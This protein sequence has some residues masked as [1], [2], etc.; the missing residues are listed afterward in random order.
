MLYIEELRLRNYRNYEEQRLT[1]NQ[2]VNIFVGENGQGKTNLLES[3]YYLATGGNFRGNKDL[4]LIR[5]DAPYFRLEARLKKETSSRYFDLEIYADRERNKQL[6]INGVKYK[7]MAEL[8][9]YLQV[10]LFSPE[11]LKIIKGGRRSADA[12][13]MRRSASWTAATTPSST[14]IKKSC[15]SAT[16]CS[17]RWLTIGQRPANWRCGMNSWCATARRSSTGGCSF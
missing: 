9:G 5:W 8:L 4:E 7:R 11:D 3:I 1:L 12:I 13:S 17:R 15:S 16:I 6:K 10:V 14:S 2:G